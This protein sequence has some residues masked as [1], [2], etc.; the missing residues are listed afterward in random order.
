MEVR[1]R[2]R[3]RLSARSPK[4]DKAL[5]RAK[6]DGLGHLILDGT[7]IPIDRLRADRLFYSGKHKKHGMNLQVIAGP[8]GQ[9]V[10]VSGAVPGS[11]HDLTAAR[12]WGIIRALTTCG[13][14]VLADKGYIG[15]DPAILVP[16]KGKDKPAPQ[17]QANR[18]HAKLR[19]PGERANAQLK[20]WKILTKLRCCPHRAGHLAKAISVLQNREAA[21]T[22]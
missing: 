1:E 22:L 9:I 20:S 6:K 15:A 11:I 7:L 21:L 17:K 3:G 14:L 19:G 10:W 13:L 2:G 12:N 18:S 4:L 5:A 16:Y 8:D